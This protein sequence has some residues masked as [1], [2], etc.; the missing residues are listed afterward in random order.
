MQCCRPLEPAAEIPKQVA[1]R[2]MVMLESATDRVGSEAGLDNQAKMLWSSGRLSRF[3]YF[4]IAE[5]QRP[6]L[7]QFT[8]WGS[9]MMTIEAR[10]EIVPP[11][12]VAIVSMP[13]LNAADAHT[14]KL[15]CMKQ[16]R[17]VRTSAKSNR[18]TGGDNQFSVW[19]FVARIAD[20]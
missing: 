11:K 8:E 9:T 4:H 16:M 20:G 17:I 18:Q 7:L 1:K 19:K 13:G 6:A 10:D 5:C 12:T 15:Y 14:A 2:A 3:G